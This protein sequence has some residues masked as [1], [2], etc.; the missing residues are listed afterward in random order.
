M[1]LRSLEL[2]KVQF[3]REQYLDRGKGTER[4]GYDKDEMLRL[5]DYW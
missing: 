3:E 1:L 2:K 5:A 4:D